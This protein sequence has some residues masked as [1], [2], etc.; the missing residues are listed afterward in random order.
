[1][2]GNTIIRP[3][4]RL[5]GHDRGP[6]H[7]GGCN[8]DFRS[9][10]LVPGGMDWRSLGGLSGGLGIC[11]DGFI[12]PLLSSSGKS[13][14]AG[15]CAT[16]HAQEVAG[17][18]R[19]TDWYLGMLILCGVVLG[20]P[21]GVSHSGMWFE[22]RC[23]Y[24]DR[25]VELDTATYPRHQERIA[26]YRGRCIPSAA[27]SGCCIVGPRFHC[28]TLFHSAM[29]WGGTTLYHTYSG[30]PVA[31]VQWPFR[32]SDSFRGKYGPGGRPDAG[33]PVGMESSSAG[34]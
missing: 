12:M 18:Q 13:W 27:S 11:G 24:W 5:V 17:R 14:G 28:G 1:M 15:G 10:T 20:T 31:A 34:I 7:R 16:I 4:G 33:G 9:G 22:H 19:F 23:Y 30:W 29:F 6:A 25:Y 3:V 21:D 8:T 2:T 26:V 32:G